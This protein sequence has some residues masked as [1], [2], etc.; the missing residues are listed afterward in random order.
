MIL[1]NS[2]SLSKCN[3]TTIL[4]NPTSHAFKAPS[5][6]WEA[7][8]VI[9]KQPPYAIRDNGKRNFLSWV[10]WGNK[11]KQID[12][13]L[14]NNEKKTTLYLY[15]FTHIWICWI[16]TVPVLKWSLTV[17]YFEKFPDVDKKYFLGTQN[18]F[19]KRNYNT[20]SKTQ[21]SPLWSG[22]YLKTNKAYQTLET[23]VQIYL[24]RTSPVAQW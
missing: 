5:I 17:K 23:N 22:I 14:Q 2:T 9:K 1:A 15:Y 4:Y 16:L 21:S 19:K 12:S 20:F 7:L 11:N 6:R 18:F 10:R 8:I 3:K 13:A 24:P